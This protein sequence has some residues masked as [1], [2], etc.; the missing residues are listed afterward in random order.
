[1]AARLALL[2]GW[3]LPF[4]LPSF[5]QSLTISPSS[6]NFGSQVVATSSNAKSATLT[7]TG[8]VQLTFTSIIASGDFSQTNTCNTNIL[9]GKK[10]TIKI[11]FAPTVL[12]AR[13]G[14]ITISDNA[15]NSPQTITLTG[16]G[17]APASLSHTTLTFSNEIVGSTSTA[18]SV[19]LTNNQS[20]SLNISSIA[21]SG[22][23][24]QTNTCGA[25]VL[26][27]GHCTIS[28]TFTPTAVGTR[29]GE[30]TIT[31]DASNSPQ[32]VTLSGTGLA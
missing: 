11:T 9:P 13:T 29:T 16:N 7:N 10:C 1:M 19:T 30:I 15:G 20:V 5:A 26:A 12:G 28:V 18:K 22:D 3:L 32:T 31:D 25:T 24:A 8:T 4:S 14:A 23:F 2:L 6:F 27:K 21:A 17:I